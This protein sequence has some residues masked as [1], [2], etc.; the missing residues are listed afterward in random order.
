MPQLFE[1]F[2][3]L[4]FTMALG[5]HM[6]P[7][8][9]MYCAPHRD[10]VLQKQTDERREKKDFYFYFFLSRF[11]FRFTEIGPSDFVG[12]RTKVFY[13]TRATHGN[14][15]HGISSSFQLKFG[16]SYVLIFLRSTAFGRSELVGAEG[17]IDPRIASYAWIPKYWSFV[18]LHEVWIFD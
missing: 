7:Y 15:K 17:Q 5:A 6:L 13:S 16:K 1:N 10:G 4:S 9:Y 8:S 11:S 12:T 14:Q 18:K 3:I 2:T